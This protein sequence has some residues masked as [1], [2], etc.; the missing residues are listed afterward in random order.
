[1]ISNLQEV[2]ARIRGVLVRRGRSTQDAEDLVQE[3]W[4]R[5]ASYEKERPVQVPEAFL[6]RTA[7]NLSIDVHRSSL[8]HGVAVDVDDEVL[9]DLAP[10]AEAVLLARERMARLSVCLGRLSGKTRDIF[11]AHRIDGK[12]YEEIAR[13]RGISVSTVGKHIAK[14]TLQLTEWMEAW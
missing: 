10:S 3:A 6:M 14:A 9:V 11:L 2:L 5:F 13:E 4:V 12:G 8:N 7:L 1:M